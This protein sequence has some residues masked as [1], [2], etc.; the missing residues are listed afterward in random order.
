[1]RA[2]FFSLILIAATAVN[3]T[4]K[5]ELTR[6]TTARPPVKLDAAG[7][8]YVN[9]PE[10]GRYQDRTYEGS[11]HSTANAIVYAFS[12]HA[13]RVD[14]GRLNETCEESKERAWIRGYAYCVCSTI[15][16]WEDRNTEGSRK[17]ER[18]EVRILVFGAESGELIDAAV[19]E[20]DLPLDMLVDPFSRYASGLY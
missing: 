5:N 18:F 6:P 11:G 9:I 17:R 16:R 8:I 12:E 15:F 3:C 1:M 20:G 4:A 13:D 2:L 7:K 10:D 19:I 14:M